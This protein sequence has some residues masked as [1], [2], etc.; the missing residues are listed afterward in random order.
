[1]A[2]R[3]QTPLE[4]A[5]SYID[6]GWNPVPVPFRS[7]EPSGKAWQTRLIDK[8]TAPHFFNCGSMNIGILLGPTSGGLTDIDLD[9]AEAI[10]IAPYLLPKTKA[11]FGRTT[12]RASHWLYYTDLSATQDNAAVRLQAPDQMTLLEVRI[13]GD[14][15]AQT[16][17]PGSVHV[18]GEPILWDE[19]GKPADVDGDHLLSRV[20]HVAAACLIARA[21][22]PRGGRHDAARMVGGLL[23]RAG[24]TEQRIK[25]AAEAIAR[26]AVDE[27]WK[28]R[29]KAAE[30]AAHEY[31]AGGRA[32]GLPKLI[33][34]N[35]EKA[36]KRI[37]DWLDYDA[38]SNHPHEEDS[39][40]NK[41]A[42]LQSVRASTVKM[43][44]VDWIW[45]DRFAFRKLG[46]LVGLPDEGKGQ[47]LSYIAARDQRERQR[48]ALQRGFRPA[49]Q[50]H[51]ADGRGRSR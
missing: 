50:C 3:Q 8:C 45:P 23:A 12:K 28:D 24:W 16:I 14:K 9:C 1:M 41:G 26:A 6:R 13:G 10:A 17:F 43:M 20:K 11:I 46:L 18:S 44:A 35:G 4:I 38:R 34:I 15:G 22:P 5:L 19:A 31:H 39:A 32:Y 36:A 47:V 29:V 25:L 48:V 30:D 33:E 49:R 7:K 21:W 51:P 37:A 40:D 27:E 42:V 2:R